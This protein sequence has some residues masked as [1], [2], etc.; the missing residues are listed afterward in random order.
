MKMRLVLAA[1][2]V[3][4]MASTAHAEMYD[5]GREW[6]ERYNAGDASRL[7]A[8]AYVAGLSDAVQGTLVTCSSGGGGS[9][10]TLASMIAD[11]LRAN[12]DVS[13]SYALGHTLARQ[14]CKPIEETK[15]RF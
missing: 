8:T 4:V 5:T 9:Y 2:G 15:Q 3:V 10:R 12:P 6:L 13:V 1:L 14:G 11:Y 7:V